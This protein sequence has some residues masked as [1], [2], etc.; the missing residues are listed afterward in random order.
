MLKYKVIWL[1]G[2]SSAGKTTISIEI[3]KKLIENDIDIMQIDADDFREIHCKDLG[4]TE[5]DRFENIKRAREYCKRCLD[6][7]IPVIASFITPYE[8]M[9]EDNRNEFGNDYFEVWMNA[10]LEKCI[11]RD[12]KGLYKDAKN[13]RLDLMTGISDDFD[14]PDSSDL[15]CYTDSENIQQTVDKVMEKICQQSSKDMED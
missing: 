14:K 11:E 7:N 10:S 2:L 3:T 9:R 15:I 12:V 13:D 8:E 1:L 6:H 5:E 4:Y